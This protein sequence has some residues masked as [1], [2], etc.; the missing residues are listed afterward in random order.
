MKNLVLP[1]LLAT[2][3]CG[4]GPTGQQFHGLYDVTGT[5]HFSIQDFGNYSAQLL[6]TFRVFEGT[7]TDL[8]LTDPAGT[9][10]L[11]ANVEGEVAS[12]EPGSTCT[13]SDNGATVTLT[14][15]RGT[16][17]FSGTSAR[18]HMSGTATAAAR[19]QLHPG[20]FFQSA[21]LT[22]VGE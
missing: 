20:S 2:G 11:L 16:L 12:L 13:R 22:R 3:L 8:V 4:C 1:A 9:C 10:L 21:T 15:T 7:T 18:L 14:L 5:A 19:G 17:S 6:D